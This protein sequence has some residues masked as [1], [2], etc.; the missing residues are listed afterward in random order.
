VNQFYNNSTGDGDYG[1][2][3]CLGPWHE[4]GIELATAPAEGIATVTARTIR[5][6]ISKGS[7]SSGLR[8]AGDRKP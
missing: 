8:D 2:R 5:E 6:E 3:D 1:E 4:K 7:R